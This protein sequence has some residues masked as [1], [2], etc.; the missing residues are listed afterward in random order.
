M[1][2][3]KDF[4]IKTKFAILFVI[5]GF[6][7]AL[8]AL[9]IIYSVSIKGLINIENFYLEHELRTVQTVINKDIDRLLSNAKDYAYW[10][11]MYNYASK[12]D[13]DW[14]KLNVTDWI[15]KN[16]GIDLILIF[17]RHGKLFYQYGDFDEFQINKDLSDN[18]LLKKVFEFRE[19]KGFYLTSK[20]IA[21]VASSQIVHTDES[22]PRNGTYLYGKLI[23]KAKLNELKRNFSPN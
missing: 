15:P 23:S 6:L 22:G 19:I 13:E 14:V 9:S 8:T 12:Q 17:D 21:L 7:I 20:G 4:S 3:F 11:D 18:A 16:F 10:D 2:R 1:R 5:D